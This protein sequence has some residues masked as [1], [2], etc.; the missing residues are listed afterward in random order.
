MPLTDSTDQHLVFSQRVKINNSCYE[1]SCIY[2][3]NELYPTFQLIKDKDTLAFERDALFICDTF[4]DCNQD[5]YVDWIVLSRMSRGKME[6]VYY[7]IPEEKRLNP[8]PDTFF[9]KPW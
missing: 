3:L 4:A 6:M 8:I 9:D 5:G 7:F 1:A 2:T